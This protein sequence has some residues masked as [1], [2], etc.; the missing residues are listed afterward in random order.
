MVMWYFLVV[1]K[2][3][4]GNLVKVIGDGTGKSRFLMVVATGLPFK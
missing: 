2:L 4:I 3:V 1:V